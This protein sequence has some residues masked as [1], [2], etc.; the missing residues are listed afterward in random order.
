MSASNDLDACVV[1]YVDDVEDVSHV[2]CDNCGPSRLDGT[3]YIISDYI[4]QLPE[5]IHSCEE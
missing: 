2:A 4:T 5:L 3:N 1:K